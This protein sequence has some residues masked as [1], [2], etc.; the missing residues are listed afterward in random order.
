MMRTREKLNEHRASRIAR[1]AVGRQQ[2][3]ATWL[4]Q[5]GR[6]VLNASLFGSSFV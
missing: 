5:K 6:I 3:E 4:L 1:L 2:R